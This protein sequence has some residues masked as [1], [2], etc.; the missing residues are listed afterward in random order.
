VQLAV[1]SIVTVVL[2]VLAHSS[3][4]VAR[5]VSALVV[6]VAIEGSG[7][8]ES[9]L[10]VAHVVSADNSGASH[11][12]AHVARSRGQ[13]N[14]LA[15]RSQSGVARVGVARV[16]LLAVDGGIG[17]SDSGVASSSVAR[18][19]GSTSDVSVRASSGWVANSSLAKVSVGARLGAVKA[20]SSV[21]CWVAHLVCALVVVLASGW[22]HTGGSTRAKSVASSS[23]GV[24]NNSLASG[25]DKSIENSLESS[26]AWN[27]GVSS[28]DTRKNGGQLNQLLLVDEGSNS[29]SKD[30]DVVC[31]GRGND[32][33]KL[34]ETDV[35]HSVSEHDNDVGN[36]RCFPS[37]KVDELAVGKG[38]TA[39]NASV[40]SIL[41]DLAHRVEERSLRVGHVD[42]QTSCSRELNERHSDLSWP[43]RVALGKAGSKLHLPHEV[44]SR[45]RSRFVKHQDKVNFLVANWSGAVPR[46][47]DGESSG[48]SSGSNVGK[49]NSS[50]SSPDRS[51]N[52]GSIGP[53]VGD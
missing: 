39:T 32:L 22:A 34:V 30:E 51:A 19:H 35:V 8:A 36:S 13:Q 52:G 7:I 44:G 53:N 1:V 43:E 21:L 11:V 47:H 27:G 12:D 3:G 45:D 17:A 42:G 49:I 4:G 16:A 15:R 18:V 29:Q 9:S 2:D 40:S 48:R 46:V 24:S 28:G 5:V 33:I 41:E 26:E 23:A 10:G 25:S 14:V 37:T 31:F 20:S 6:V 38:D 50:A